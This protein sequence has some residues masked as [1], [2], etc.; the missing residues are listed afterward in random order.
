M[1][2]VSGMGSV[3]EEVVSAQALSPGEMEM[4]ANVNVVYKIR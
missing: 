4:V 3:D 2:A 1:K